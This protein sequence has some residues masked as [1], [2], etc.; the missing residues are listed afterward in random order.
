MLQ[1][2][3]TYFVKKFLKKYLDKLLGGKMKKGKKKPW[4]KSKAVLTAI[5]ATLLGGLEA[6]SAALGMPVKVPM[7]VFEILGGLGLYA[8]RTAKKE[9]K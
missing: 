3:K 7:Y 9:I 1:K 4:Y 5:I 2:I 8:L 6:I